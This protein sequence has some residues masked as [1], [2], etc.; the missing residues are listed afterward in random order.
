MIKSNFG[1]FKRC[2]FCDFDG[3][4]TAV[5]T[6]VAMFHKFGSKRLSE[7]GPEMYAKR[8]T[9]RQGVKEIV[10]SIESERFPEILEFVKA[11]PLRPGLDD[12]LDFLEEKEVPFIVISG[13]MAGMVK[14]R[15]SSLLD[16][17]H[18]VYAPEVDLSGEY[19]RLYSD[20]EEGG[21]LLAKARVMELF[22]IEEA[23]AIGDGV[24]D[25]TMASKA[26]TAF[27]RDGL[28]GYLDD[29][30]VSYSA[31]ND[32]HDVRDALVLRWK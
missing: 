4:I 20:F 19:I 11:Q 31:W 25:I 10:G 9:I 16:R 32:F 18:A 7:I 24:T 5:E 28:Q 27:A 2:V 3:T 14:T 29:L 26:S 15:L 22:D 17:I 12:L 23:V 6:F 8:M 21:E 13:G 1:P 30:G